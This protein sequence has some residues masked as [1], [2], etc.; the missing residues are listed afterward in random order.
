MVLNDDDLGIKNP[1]QHQHREHREKVENEQHPRL[2]RVQPDLQRRD[3]RLHS[4]NGCLH[5]AQPGVD[6]VRELV[7][8]GDS[9]GCDVARGEAGKGGDWVWGFLSTAARLTRP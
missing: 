4:L 7:E 3:V 2:A 6:E 5:L 1:S 9:L 8:R